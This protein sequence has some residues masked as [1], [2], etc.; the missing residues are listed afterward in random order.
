MK[1]DRA[2][3]ARQVKSWLGRGLFA[4]DNLLGNSHVQLRPAYYSCWAFDGLLEM[5]WTCEVNEGSENR[6]VWV[7][8]NG[9]EARF[10]SDVLV[11]GVKTLP[12]R[13]LDRVGP[14]ELDEAEAFEPEYLAGWPTILYDE[15]VGD[16]SLS[17]REKVI[18]ELRP[19]VYSVIE[20]GRQKRNVNVS[21]GTW[22]NMTFKHI[23]IPLWI[24]SY[25]YQGKEYRLLVNGQ[26]GKVNGD[27]PSDFVKMTFAG[28]TVVMFIFLLVFLYLLFTNQL[29]F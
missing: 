3:V 16:A 15:S 19:Q 14:F 6:P 23:L 20:P 12:L 8:R 21:S 1:N 7:S 13:D 5:R 18:R 4:P 9:T 22:S 11:P 17:G 24:G 10:F 29:P 26:T 27:K 25:S 28:L 2:E